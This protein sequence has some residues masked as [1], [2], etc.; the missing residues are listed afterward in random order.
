[1]QTRFFCFPDMET[2]FTLAQAAG[3]TTINAQGEPELIRFSHDYALDVVGEIYAPTDN[4]L[5]DG[6][7][8]MRKVPGWHVNARIINGE[9]LPESFAQ[10]EVFPATPARDFA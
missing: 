10:Y 3:L 1:M 5:E 8:V 2:S 7:P 9:P 6:T 4:Q